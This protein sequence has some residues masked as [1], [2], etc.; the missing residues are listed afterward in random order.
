LAHNATVQSGCS[1]LRNAATHFTVDV[2]VGTPLPGQPQQKFDLVA[3][4]GSDFVIVASCMCRSSGSCEPQNKCFTGTNRSSTFSMGTALRMKASSQKNQIPS[5]V[6][7]FGSGQI[8]TAIISDQVTVGRVSTYMPDALMLMTNQNLDITG[9]FEG[10]MGLG[11][12]KLPF[13]PSDSS[14]SSPRVRGFLEEAGVERFSMCFNRG[15]DGV[16]RLGAS[17]PPL[18]MESIGQMHWS[19]DFRGISVG[20]GRAERRR[21]APRQRRERRRMS[22]ICSEV[23]NGQETACGAIPDSGTTLV[24]APAEHIRVLFEEIC[25]QWPRCQEAAEEAGGEPTSMLF[26]DLL[27][28]CSSWLGSGPEALNQEL[29]PLHFTVAGRHGTPQVL[30]LLPDVY[31][32]AMFPNEVKRLADNRLVSYPRQVSGSIASSDMVC[33]AAFGSVEFHTAKNGPV[34]IFGTPFFYSYQVGYDQGSPD[35][36]RNASISFSKEPCGSCTE[37]AGEGFLASS[38]EVT[39]NHTSTQPGL[40][41]QGIRR[42]RGQIRKPSFGTSRAL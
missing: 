30:T 33:S 41:W 16:L 36:S 35:G 19:L 18:A 21:L 37:V 4:T 28:N 13:S 40:T 7:T 15:A 12:V 8:H 32:V 34:W 25:S 20:S 2:K 31:V 27:Q 3:D 5:L 26:Q 6:V 22:R 29:P 14:A 39:L 11:V 1:P 38:E 17:P 42:L 24:M 23:P 9:P 10:I